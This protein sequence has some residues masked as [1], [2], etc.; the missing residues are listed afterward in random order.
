MYGKCIVADFNSVHKDKCLT[1]FLRLKDCYVVSLPSSSNFELDDYAHRCA[2]RCEE[3]I[4][5][6]FYWYM[7]LE[8]SCS[9]LHDDGS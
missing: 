4:K 9:V 3:G 8:P 7:A 5:G 6:W 1:E 2:D